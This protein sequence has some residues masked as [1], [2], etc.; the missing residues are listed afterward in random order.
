MKVYEVVDSTSDEMYFHLGIFL[1]LDEAK[2]EILGCD[3]DKAITDTGE[4]DDCEEI[5]I[6]ERVIGWSTYGKTVFKVTRECVLS[7]E[8]DEQMWNVV[9]AI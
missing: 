1:T 7:E 3:E 2:Q 6:I 8:T 4:C 9:E 5:S